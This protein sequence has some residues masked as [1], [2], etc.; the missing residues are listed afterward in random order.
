MNEQAVDYLQQAISLMGKPDYDQARKL[1]EKALELEPRYADAY[2]VLGDICANQDDLDGAMEQY[3]KV[4]VA[5]PDYAEAYFDIGNICFLQDDYAKGVE[6][7]NK[8]DEKG[9]HYFRLYLN[10]A[11]IYRQIGSEEIA[12][13]NYN[14]AIREEPLRA[15]LRLEKA[16]Y[17]LELGNV[18]E[19]LE[20][21]DELQAIEPDL[22]DAYALRAQAL[23]RIDRHGD[24]LELAR[25]A[26]GR[27]PDDP[28]VSLLLAQVLLASGKLD[29]TQKI[30]EELR[31]N[32]DFPLAA[33]SVRLLEAQVFASKQEFAKAGESLRE[34]IREETKFDDQARYLLMYVYYAMNDAEHALEIAGELSRSGINNAYTACGKFFVPF[35]LKRQGKKEE[36][37]ALFRG[38]TS[39]FR[40]I[41]V[42]NP[43]F[44]EGYLYRILSHKE[45]G[46]YDK[47]LE[48]TEYVEALDETSVDAYALR[49]SIYKDM[50][51]EENASRMKKKVHAIDPLFEL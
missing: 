21:L 47:A 26:A 18:E 39:E 35:L 51:D 8:A 16:E 46:E 5:D 30:L 20:T 32:K 6:Y 15:E 23:C 10:L 13:R 2:S 34:I 33:R 7:Y 4:L 48:L 11:Q 43:H 37:A 29:E 49:Y 25:K 44:Y 9:Y 19:A 42:N 36:A 38:L 41:T 3:R 1:A 22:Y 45:L 14:R 50:G 31:G 40:R 24:A 27:F 12:L 28:S 17:H